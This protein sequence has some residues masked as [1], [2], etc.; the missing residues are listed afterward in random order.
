MKTE[1]G[2]QE[3]ANE[4]IDENVALGA[5]GNVPL[6]TNRKVNGRYQVPYTVAYSLSSN[7]KILL[8]E[9]II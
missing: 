1:E 2:L 6:W 3:L 4:P 8:V 5:A 9:N 7:S